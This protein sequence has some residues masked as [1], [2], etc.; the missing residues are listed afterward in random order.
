MDRGGRSIGVRH[1]GDAAARLADAARCLFG[2]VVRRYEVLAT[3]YQRLRA[4]VL[5]A[6]QFRSL[7]LDVAVPDPRQAARWNPDARLAGAVVDRYE[8]RVAVLT[9]LWAQGVGH[10]GAPT[11]WYAYNAV[12]GA[13][14][15]DRELWPTRG[16]VRRTASLFDG[17]LAA[18][19]RGVLEA[20]VRASRN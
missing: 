14:D 5:D 16:G 18:T 6:A 19:K 10:T 9:R 7:V 17:N 1:V 4:T 12:V 20:L 2:E 15:H 3:Q 8:L 13:I 11:A